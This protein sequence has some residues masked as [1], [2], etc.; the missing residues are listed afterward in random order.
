MD[1]I[2]INVQKVGYHTSDRTLFEL[3]NV[4]FPYVNPTYGDERS[5]CD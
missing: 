2:R 4:G 1:I 5:H 3:M